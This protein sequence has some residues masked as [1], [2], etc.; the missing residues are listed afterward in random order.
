MS[1]IQIYLTSKEI[2]KTIVQRS[3][4]FRIPLKLICHAVQIKYEPF[5]REYINAEDSSNYKIEEEKFEK[6]LNLL[7]VETRV[8]LVLKKNFGEN[9]IR[10]Q[11]QEEYKSTENLK[12]NAKRTVKRV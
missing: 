10:E 2:K 8:T 5:I 12:T 3:Q 7:G 9:E 1:T 4:D 11:L 6:I